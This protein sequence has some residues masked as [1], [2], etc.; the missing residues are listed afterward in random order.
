MVGVPLPNLVPLPL[1]FGRV[2]LCLLHCGLFLLPR[3]PICFFESRIS[4]L[5]ETLLLGMD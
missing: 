3:L 1:R 4:F 2:V 5:L